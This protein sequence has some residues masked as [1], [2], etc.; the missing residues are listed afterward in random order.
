MLIATS[1]FFKDNKIA[2]ACK[3]CEIFSLLKIFKSFI[4][5]KLHKKSFCFIFLLYMKKASQKVNINKMLTAHAICNLDT[6]K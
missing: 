4:Y 2:R 6:Y 1:E 3:V 5:T